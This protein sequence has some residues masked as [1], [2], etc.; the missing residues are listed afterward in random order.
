[1]NLVTC[2]HTEPQGHQYEEGYIIGR[3][4]ES[5]TWGSLVNLQQSD[6]GTNLIVAN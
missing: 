5:I 6:E 4:G 1:M 3:V 2:D